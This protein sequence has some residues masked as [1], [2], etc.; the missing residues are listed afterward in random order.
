MLS[1]IKSFRHGNLFAEKKKEK[2]NKKELQNCGAGK[3]RLISLICSYPIL[4]SFSFYFFSNYSISTKHLHCLFLG[5]K[6]FDVRSIKLSYCSSARS[7]SV[8]PKCG[9]S[10]Y[11]LIQK[12]QLLES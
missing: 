5:L 3:T 7:C 10:G 8:I 9:P 11:I 12:A 2:E 1:F 6:L 4:F